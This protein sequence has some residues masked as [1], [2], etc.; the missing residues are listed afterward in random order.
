M[1][2]V[3]TLGPVDPWD[4]LPDEGP[5]AWQ[6]FQMYLAM[7]SSTQYHGSLTTVP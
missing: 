1:N 3:E 5:K 4:R 6:A 2:D 7:G